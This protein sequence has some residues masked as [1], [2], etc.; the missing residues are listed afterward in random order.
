LPNAGLTIFHIKSHLQVQARIEYM[1][2]LQ[3][4]SLLSGSVAASAP[5]SWGGPA[6]RRSS[7]RLLGRSHKHLPK[8]PAL[9]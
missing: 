9:G 3:P 2:M 7:V 5:C 8:I 1:R 6:A 4:A